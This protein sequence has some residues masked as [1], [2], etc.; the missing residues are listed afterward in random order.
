MKN[1]FLAVIGSLL[2]SA[3]VSVS[4]S[5]D[6][7]ALLRFNQKNLTEA[8]LEPW[9]QQSLYDIR[10]EAWE[11]QQALLEQGALDR[12]IKEQAV[13]QGKSVDEIRTALLS[14]AP[15]SDQDIQSFYDNYRAHI[16]APLSEV[17][18]AIREQ[19]E[20]MR[21]Q[22]Q[23]AA[24]MEKLRQEH[25]MKVLVPEP[26]APVFKLPLEGYPV[27]GKADAPFTLVEFADYRCPYCKKGAE[28]VN[29]L[30]DAF[31]GSLKVYYVD[32]PVVDP[33]SG[34][35]ITVMRGA[36]C[37]GQQDKYWDYHELAY[38]QQGAL[39]K[40]APGAIAAK[41]GLN[42]RAF[43]DCMASKESQAFV[44][45]ATDFGRRYGVSSTPTYFLNGKR[46]SGADI[47][48]Q[49]QRQLNPSKSS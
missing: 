47:E 33:A 21:E 39:S 27:K 24:V 31:P 6:S 12:Y 9:V 20:S 1:R 42:T 19:L 34:I 37:A 10:H 13:I 7:D 48:S 46:F 5:A 2:V 25:G 49:I 28:M 26:E 11:S 32:F 3:S 38:A 36:W 22:Q 17:R 18:D 35:S 30:M 41:L 40:N 23:L 45:K 44:D 16:Q 14:T 15:V 29:R 43:E 4:V 8:Q